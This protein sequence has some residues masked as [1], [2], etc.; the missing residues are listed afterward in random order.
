[1]ALNYCKFLEVVHITDT[2]VCQNLHVVKGHFLDYEP[3]AVTLTV[4]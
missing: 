3:H 1:M 4:R 2:C